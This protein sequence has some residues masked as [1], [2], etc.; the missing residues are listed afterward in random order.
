[1]T[2]KKKISTAQHQRHVTLIETKRKKKS[3]LFALRVTLTAI[4][5]WHQAI[6]F[7]R[8]EQLNLKRKKLNETRLSG[9]R[10]SQTLPINNMQMKQLDIECDR[11]EKRNT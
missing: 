1:M 10:R 9:Y 3:E 7:A 4:V 11:T 8:S 2:T 5:A 6:G